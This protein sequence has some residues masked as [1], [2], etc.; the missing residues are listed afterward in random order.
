MRWWLSY[1][2]AWSF[3][4]MVDKEILNDIMPLLEFLLFIAN[5]GLPS[6][7]RCTSE[8]KAVTIQELS[9]GNNSLTCS[10]L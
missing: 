5:L 6:P 8:V 1:P 9:K 3:N 4:Q 2:G 7:S 10:R